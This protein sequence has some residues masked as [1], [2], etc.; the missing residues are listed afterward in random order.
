MVLPA[1]LAHMALTS[2]R[3][4]KQ[5][6][7]VDACPLCSQQE[8]AV[9]MQMRFLLLF[10]RGMFLQPFWLLPL[11]SSFCSVRRGHPLKLKS[12]RRQ[13]FCS[14]RE[15]NCAA[16]PLRPHCDYAAAN[17]RQFQHAAAGAAGAADPAQNP[18]PDPAPSASRGTGASA[19]GASDPAV[20]AGPADPSAAG[21]QVPQAAASAEAPGTQAA[22]QGARD[23]SGG[24][25]AGLQ[26]SASVRAQDIAG[27]AGQQPGSPPR[28]AG[29]EA[30]GAAT[31]D[32]ED[33]GGR[34][35]APLS[36]SRRTGVQST[37]ARSRAQA[38]P[39][40]AA[41]PVAPISR[42]GAAQARSSPVGASRTAPDAAPGHSVKQEGGAALAPADAGA[43]SR[44][45]SAREGRG[46]GGGGTARGAV[47]AAA[48][49]CGPKQEGT[50][51]A[52]ACPA[53]SAGSGGTLPGASCAGTPEGG[54]ERGETGPGAAPST[55][56]SVAPGPSGLLPPPARSAAAELRRIVA[57]GGELEELEAAAAP[58]GG[59]AAHALR[60]DPVPYPPPEPQALIHGSS[61]ALGSPAAHM[62]SGMTL[63]H[64]CTRVLRRCEQAHLQNQVFF[65]YSPRTGRWLLLASGDIRSG[66]GLSHHANAKDMSAQEA[67]TQAGI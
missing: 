7:Y 19:A 35:P 28:S 40:H 47:C 32:M 17:G 59:P 41:A 56:L 46:P 30:P 50:Q 27:E 67:A 52:T 16:C 64:V 58:S 20:N 57:A 55:R 15:P 63:H 14:K 4:V 39:L 36:P 21:D 31:A 49:A 13:V 48:P 18:A 51:S 25:D 23:A 8:M 61:G 10:S 2:P 45:G 33:L 12:V 42:P 54:P 22:A 3:S 6:S 26:A 60:R 66:A 38:R 24:A 5:C 44:P 11:P 53:G 34:A 29:A 62:R 1:R 37:A 43:A 9:L 65:L